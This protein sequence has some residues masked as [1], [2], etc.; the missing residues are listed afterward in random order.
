ML[1][2]KKI[3]EDLLQEYE[4]VATVTLG[5]KMGVRELYAR[6]IQAAKQEAAAKETPPGELEPNG[7]Q[8]SKPNRKKK[9]RE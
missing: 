4:D 9:A 3:A 1:D 6:I 2:I 5:K 8:V 7:Q